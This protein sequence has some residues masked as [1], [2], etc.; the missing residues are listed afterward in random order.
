M[1]SQR[2]WGGGDKDGGALAMSAMLDGVQCA[3]GKTTHLQSVSVVV[4][5][6]CMFSGCHQKLHDNKLSAGL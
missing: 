2:G 1:K 3:S 6:V 5:A 4:R